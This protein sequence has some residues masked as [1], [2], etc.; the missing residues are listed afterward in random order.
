[1]ILHLV[2]Q[3]PRHSDALQQCLSACQP[4][5]AVLLLDDGLSLL[6]DLQLLEEY[7]AA[8]P[9]VRW[10]ALIGDQQSTESIQNLKNEIQLIDFKEFVDLAIDYY[11]TVSW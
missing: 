8:T 10:L 3:S 5:D 2:N 7:T 9:Q 11:P 1:M 4:G 6:G